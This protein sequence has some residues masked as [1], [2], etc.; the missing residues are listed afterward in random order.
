MASNDWFDFGGIVTQYAIGVGG[1]GFLSGID[2]SFELALE[3]S[4]MYIL[5]RH[6]VLV[7]LAIIE[8]YERLYPEG[9]HFLGLIDRND[10][11]VSKIDFYSAPFLRCVSANNFRNELGLEYLAAYQRAF[12]LISISHDAS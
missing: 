2:R 8:F 5:S 12:S 4:W 7:F 11:S 1:K 9:I 6:Q 10:F 3:R